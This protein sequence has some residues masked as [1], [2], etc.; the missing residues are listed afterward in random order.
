MKIQM[1]TMI[2][3]LTSSLSASAQQVLEKYEC[4]KEDSSEMIIE[5]KDQGDENTLSFQYDNVYGLSLIHI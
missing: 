4:I 5:L 3:L 2:V 1:I